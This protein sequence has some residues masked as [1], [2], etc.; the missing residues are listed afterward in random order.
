MIVIV[1]NRIKLGAAK[2][3]I[4]SLAEGLTVSDP[5]AA[6]INGRSEVAQVALVSD[7]IG[8][9]ASLVGSRE[10]LG[11]QCNAQLRGE[12]APVTRSVCQGG[13]GVG[14][15]DVLQF[16]AVLKDVTAEADG[17]VVLDIDTLEFPAVLEGSVIDC[18]DAGGQG[19]LG[20]L[21]AVVE[22][23]GADGS[24]TA[25][26]GERGQTLTAYEGL[27]ADAGHVIVDGNAGEVVTPGGVGVPNAGAVVAVGIHRPATAD[28]QLGVLTVLFAERPVGIVAALAADGA[29]GH[30]KAIKRRTT[31]EC[32][33]V[34]RTGLR[35][36]AFH[37]A[38]SVLE[39]HIG[40]GDAVRGFKSKLR[41]VCGM[42][43]HACNV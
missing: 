16:S 34:R 5:L 20:E 12:A 29:V 8:G 15:D 26:D 32:D 24:D 9:G 6:I 7:G 35:I 21:V 31:G 27:G 18:G 10:E 4:A 28:G 43:T 17:T 39:R 3:D 25:A 14:E 42:D 38:A 22:G 2:G 13:G 11:A 40:N 1:T 23:I 36:G 33:R 19:D 41:F 37:H 30:L